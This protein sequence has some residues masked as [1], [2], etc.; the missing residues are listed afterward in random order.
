MRNEDRGGLFT[1]LHDEDP[2]GAKFLDEP[3]GGNADC[4]HEKGDLLL[5]AG[6]ERDSC[7][8][9]TVAYSTR[10]AGKVESDE[11]WPSNNICNSKFMTPRIPWLRFLNLRWS[12]I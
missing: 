3:F 9:R 1:Y 6:N 2:R 11:P 10:T 8:Q 12:K 4:R 7:V 5:Y